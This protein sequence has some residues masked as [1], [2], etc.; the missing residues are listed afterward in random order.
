MTKSVLY[1]WNNIEWIKKIFQDFQDTHEKW[2]T[3]YTN[4]IDVPLLLFHFVSVYSQ[5]ERSFAKTLLF[6]CLFRARLTS[7]QM[8]ISYIKNWFRWNDSKKLAM[9]KFR[10]NL[11][12]CVH[13]PLINAY[14]CRTN[15]SV[16]SFDKEPTLCTYFR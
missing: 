7:K 5:D 4:F 16:E 14:V 11:F 1:L 2:D 10:D 15:S 3:L 6:W 12:G 13:I 8:L 9:S